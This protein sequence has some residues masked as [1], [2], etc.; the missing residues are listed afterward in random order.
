MTETNVQCIKCGSPAGNE[1]S[2]CPGCGSSLNLQKKISGR[3]IK[4]VWKWVIF[5]LIAI[6]IFEYIFASAAGQLYLLIKGTEFTE[7]ETGVVVSSLGSLL[8]IFCGA[9]Y[10]SYMSPGFSIKEPMIGASVEIIISQ[11][12]LLVI[13]GTFNFLVI[14]RIIVIMTVAFCGAKAGDV[15]QRRKFKRF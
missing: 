5:S 14:V 12:I 1:F 3:K 10:S 9:F 7:L 4:I 15:L 6:L 2:Y 13:A 8:G 11:I